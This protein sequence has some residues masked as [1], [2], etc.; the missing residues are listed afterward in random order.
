MPGK[1][2]DPL[3]LEYMDGRR[4]K[5]TKAFDYRLGQPLGA[6]YVRVPAGFVTDFAS[7]PKILW[8]VLPPTGP[9][10]KAAVIHDWLY[11]RQAIMPTLRLCDQAEADRVLLEAMGVLDVS[12][13]ARLTIYAGVRV[14]GSF[15]WNR[16]RKARP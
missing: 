7:I 12:Y 6:E 16:Y 15:T 11:Q 4:W 9:Y 5:L 1:F 3:E 13:V 2:L 14:G 10:G 8:N